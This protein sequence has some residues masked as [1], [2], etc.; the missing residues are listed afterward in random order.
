MEARRSI[1]EVGGS[2]LKL[3]CSLQK[4]KF[5]ALLKF[6]EVDLVKVRWEH[7][8]AFLKMQNIAKHA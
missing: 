3:D 7:K 1:L 5:E 4:S 6:F 8:N 2:D